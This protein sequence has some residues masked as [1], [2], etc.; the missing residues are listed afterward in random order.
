M[1][2]QQ[3]NLA[4]NYVQRLSIRGFIIS[5]GMPRFQALHVSPQLVL[6]EAND[7]SPCCIVAHDMRSL[8]A[9]VLGMVKTAMKRFDDVNIKWFE[10]LVYFFF[11][12][13]YFS[14]SR[15]AQ[16]SKLD[17]YSSLTSNITIMIIPIKCTVVVIRHVYMY[18]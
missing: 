12:F 2:K 3:T 16:L 13:L 9:L 5:S 1:Y 17:L 11:F 18:L 14:C 6:C 10:S 4:E 15:P 8:D 7:P